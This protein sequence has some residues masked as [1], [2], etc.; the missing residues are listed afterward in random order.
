MPLV[1]I[2]YDQSYFQGKDVASLQPAGYDDYGNAS[3][4]YPE[5]ADVLGS[6][7][8]AKCLTLG[9]A[10]QGKKILIVGCAYS[11][12][13][14]ALIDLGGD[15]YGLDISAWAFSQSIVPTKHLVGDARLDA[16]FVRAKTLA[17]ITGNKKF[18]VIFSEDLLCCLTDAEVITF[19]AL[20]N[21]YGSLVIHFISAF[22][23]LSQWYNYHTIAEY[24]AMLPGSNHDRFYTRFAWSE[25]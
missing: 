24:K 13:V 17:G 6:T 5:T 23:H 12:L 15:A 16:D 4:Y 14:K 19:C 11:K 10:I 1:P 20:A 7:L 25:T 18:D 22:P 3:T 8:V 2:V 21:K 9:V